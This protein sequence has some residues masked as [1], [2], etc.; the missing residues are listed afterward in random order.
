VGP[1][2]YLGQHFL[3]APAIAKKIADA[4]PAGAGERVLEIGPGRGALSVHLLKKFPGMHLVEVDSDAVNALRDKLRGNDMNDGILPPGPAADQYIIHNE[5]VM[6]FDFSKAGFPIHVVGNLPYNIGARVIKKTLMYAP[7]VLSC[8][9]M[10][11]KEVA[12]RIVSGPGSKQNGFLS[13]FCQFFGR[14][15][16]LFHV[17]PGAFFP[18]PNVESSV[19]QII[20]DQDVEKKLERELWDDFFSFADCGFSMRRKQLAKTLSLKLGKD[21]DFYRDTLSSMGIGADARPEDLGVGGWLDLY[22]RVR[23]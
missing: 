6:A 11:Q 19:F 22:K 13:I 5:D 2:K 23:Q 17:P 3:T 14:A 15:K 12:E 20:V 1:K 8:T 4:V 18:R 7:R 16:L 9:F 21:K 10:V